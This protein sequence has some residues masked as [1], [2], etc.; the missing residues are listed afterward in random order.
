MHFLKTAQKKCTFKKHTSC[1][2][3]RNV[4]FAGHWC[5]RILWRNTLT[6]RT[7]DADYPMIWFANTG[8]SHTDE[9]GWSLVSGWLALQEPGVC[10]GKGYKCNSKICNMPLSFCVPEIIFCCAVP[11]LYGEELLEKSIHRFWCRMPWAGSLAS[12]AKV[13]QVDGD[14]GSLMKS[15]KSE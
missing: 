11:P 12:P 7:C 1:K 9:A 14:N 6:P 15:C 13:S 3:K 5:V 8:S 4:L 10:T 2:K